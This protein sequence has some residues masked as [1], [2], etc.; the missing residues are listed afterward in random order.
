MQESVVE[1]EFDEE[2]FDKLQEEESDE[3]LGGKIN[4][5]ISDCGDE[6]THG[7]VNRISPSF[8]TKGKKSVAPP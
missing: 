8:V 1:E 7:H 5:A 2:E 6:A 3:M 4:L